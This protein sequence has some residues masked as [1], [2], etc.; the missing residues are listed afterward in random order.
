MPEL[1]IERMIEPLYGRVPHPADPVTRTRTS[2]LLS[3][4][5][6]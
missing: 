3:E 5:I 6:A 1:M 4:A 2:H